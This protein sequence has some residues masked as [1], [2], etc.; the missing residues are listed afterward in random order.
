MTLLVSL[1]IVSYSS[2]ELIYI[3]VLWTCLFIPISYFSAKKSVKYVSDSL[4]SS[5]EVSAST[6]EVV[7]NHELI[8]AFGTES[9]ETSRYDK[10]LEKERICYNRA[11]HKIDLTDFAQRL[12]QISLPI[13]FAIFLITSEKFSKMTPGSIASIFS[14]T[15]ILT[16]QIGDFG[17]GLLG[18]ME[19]RERIRVALNKLKC[20]PQSVIGIKEGEL[21][22][23]SWNIRFENVDFS[24]G[25]ESPAISHINLEIKENEKIGIIGYSGAG[26]TTLIKLLRGF[27]SPTYGQIFI[28]GIP[29]DQISPRA[30]SQNIAEVSQSIPLFHRTVRENVIYGCPNVSDQEIWEVL[31]QAQIADTIK[32]LP[33]GLDAIV[34]VRGQRLSGG[35]KARIAIARAI[36]RQSKIIIFDEATAAIDSESELLIQKGMEEL[37]KGRTLIAIAHRLSTLRKINRI[38]VMDKGQ[39]IAEGTHDEL[40]KQNALY[41]RL[42]NAQVV[43]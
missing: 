11:Q 38:I 2:L 41:C 1:L 8:P 22:P 25:K 15:L 29:L 21:T 28:G 40:L 26:K 27:Y 39:I 37:V 18:T 5:A 31:N 12:L 23:T 13:V 36:I 10:V 35:E 6:V 7:E 34:G 9:F 16:N 30:L 4:L 17:K 42:W 19:I 14:F 3:F 43:L 20:P 24:Y 33:E 32:K